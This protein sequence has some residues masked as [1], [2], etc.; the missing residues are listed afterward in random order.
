L[1]T[2]PFD[3]TSFVQLFVAFFASRKFETMGQKAAKS[4]EREKPNF[5]N[6]LHFT[7]DFCPFSH[8]ARF[9][10]ALR[11]P[12]ED[13]T[14]IHIPYS[15]QLE[16]AS[17][18]GRD[19]E[20]AQLNRTPYEGKSLDEL[21][22]EKDAF[23]ANINSN[24]MVPALKLPSGKILVESEVVMEYYE[25]AAPKDADSLIPSCP[26]TA[27]HMRFIMKRLNATNTPI[28]GLLNNQDPERD[29][30][31]AEEIRSSLTNFAKSLDPNGPFCVGKSLTL[32]DVMAGPFLYRL[33][34]GLSHWRG[35]SFTNAANVGEDTAKR[36]K[37]LLDAIAE[38]DAFKVGLVSDTEIARNY[39]FPAHGK[40]W[41]A[42]GKSFNGRGVSK[43]SS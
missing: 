17:H 4:L 33:D 9:V 39:A 23:C 32:A 5:A 8:R 35:F 38:L 40:S 25:L 27:A 16:I 11:F 28:F 29:A 2:E 26:E 24:G 18:V 36:I 42:D 19:S 41:A 21:Y 13:I 31:F 37:I 12:K 20:Q 15:R 22:Q 1:Q 30:T 34:V 7:N 43:L 3:S 14:T 6:L 10:R